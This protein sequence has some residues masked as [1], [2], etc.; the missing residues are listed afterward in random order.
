MLHYL[1]QVNFTTKNGE[2]VYFDAR[3]DPVARYTL[4]NWQ[5][6]YEGIITF[7]SIG[8][9]DTS[10]PEGQQIQMKDNTDAIWAGNQKNVNNNNNLS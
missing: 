3:G 5:M 2:N 4:V 9:Y 1:T 10:K 6:N 7:E 8:L